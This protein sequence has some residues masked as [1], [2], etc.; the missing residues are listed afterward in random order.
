MIEASMFHVFVVRDLVHVLSLFYKNFRDNTSHC[1][2]NPPKKNWVFAMKIQVGLPSKKAGPIILE[3][4]NGKRETIINSKIPQ[5]PGFFKQD[6]D[7]FNN[8]RL[9]KNLLKWS[10][11]D[12]QGNVFRT[13]TYPEKNLENSKDD[14]LNRLFLTCLSPKLNIIREKDGTPNRGPRVFST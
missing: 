11:L 5:D 9:D 4:T 3:P 1:R 2:N 6:F 8:S 7:P 12:F 13:P 10:N 14:E